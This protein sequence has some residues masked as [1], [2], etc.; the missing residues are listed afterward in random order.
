AIDTE[1][2][3]VLLP[4]LLVLLLGVAAAAAVHRVYRLDAR[5]RDRD[6]RRVRRQV[7]RETE[8]VTAQAEATLRVASDHFRTHLRSILDVAP[9][10]FVAV[11]RAG[12]VSYANA[13]AA[14]LFGRP[15]DD[16]M[17]R[18]LPDAWPALGDELLR[19]LST[20]I[21]GAPVERTLTDP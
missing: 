4:A 19:A 3:A 21:G 8:Q 6:A 9:T 18:Q 5:D 12:W 16:V 14:T 15:L 1:S 17:G 11:D 13:A 20:S 2:V 10:P 7:L